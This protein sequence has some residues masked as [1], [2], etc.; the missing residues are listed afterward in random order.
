MPTTPKQWTRKRDSNILK[1][2]AVNSLKRASDAFNSSNDEGRVTTVLILLHHSFEMLIKAAFVGN[3][4]QVMDVASG[5]S[6][7]FERCL[8]MAQQHLGLTLEDIGLLRTLDAMRDDEQ[9]YFTILSEGILHLHCRAAVSIFDSILWKCFGQRLADSLPVRVLPLSTAPPENPQ[10][11]IDRQFS[12]IRTM[13][14]PGQRRQGDARGLIRGLLILGGHQAEGPFQVKE[15]DVDY[16]TRAIRKGKGRSDVFPNLTALATASDEGGRLQLT[17]RFVQ[18]KDAMP[19]RYTEDLDNAVAIREYDSNQRFQWRP[20][21]LAEKLNI[22]GERCKAL[23]WKME[24]E[25]DPAC[26]R[27]I[28]EGKTTIPKYSDLALR[29]LREGLIE[30]DMGAVLTEYRTARA[31]LVP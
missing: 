31:S 17:V 18:N 2:K 12:Q 6:W 5:R 21:V 4:H 28:V 30:L 7:G 14:S 23:R 1:Q 24:I 9:H 10:I 15:R 25:N 26:R 20:S 3:G 19:M 27:D 11:L 29:R 8:S 13:L 16:A 22:N